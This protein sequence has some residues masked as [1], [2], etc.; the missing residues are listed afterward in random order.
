MP[1]VFYSPRLTLVRAQQHIN[2]FKN[3]VQEFTDSKPWE[4]RV[5]K[6]SRPGQAFHKVIFTRELPEMLPCILFDAT[7]NLRAALD[8][9]GYASAVAAKSP[10]LK[11]TKFPFGPCERDW[12]NNLAGGCK[13]LPQAI[14]AIF[15][16]ARSYKGGDDILWAVNEIANAKKHLALRPLVITAPS[17]FFTAR[18]VGPGGLEEIVSPGGFGIGW[19]GN[20]REI[21]LWSGPE[22][23]LVDLEANVTFTVAVDGMDVI[24]NCQTTLFLTAAY[25]KIAR[26]VADAEAECRRIGFLA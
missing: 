12:Q 21:T 18:S 2:D 13:D 16:N 22:S 3:S 8:Q 6:E 15:E 1:D 24:S 14:R 19:D 9:A 20:K 4:Y 7:N 5:D 23:T 25:Q 10:S 11:A 17:A 26:I